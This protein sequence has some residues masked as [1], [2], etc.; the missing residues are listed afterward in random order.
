M[1]QQKIIYSLLLITLTIFNLNAQDFWKDKQVYTVGTE[2]HAATH[3]VY[4]NEA[5]ALKGNYQESPYYKSLAGNWKFNWAETPKDKPKDFHLSNFNVDDWSTIPVPACWERHGYGAPSHRGLGALVRAEKIK[6]PGVPDNDNHVGSYRTSF[7]IPKGWKNR[8]TLLHFNG[9]SSAFYLWINGELVGYD[10]DAMTSSVFDI[11]SFLKEGE[12]TIAVQ[13]YRWTTGSYL[14]SG[15]T[16]TFSGIFRDVYLQSRPNVQIKDFFLTSNL[17]KQYVDAKFNA[18]IKIHNNSEVVPKNYKVKIDIYDDAGEL[19]SESGDK[20]PKIGWRMG[21]LGAET[22]LEYNTNIKSPKLWS[23]EF[24]NL[25]TVVITL[26][27]AEGKTVEVT[28]SPFG[29]REIEMKNLQVHINGVP[30]KIKGA[31]RGE[32]HPETGK[33]LSEASMIQDILLMKQNNFNSVRSSHHPNDPR[34]YALCDKY[35]LYVMDEALESPDYFIRGN[36]LPGSD[37]GWMGAAL[38]RAVAMVERSKNHPSIIFWSLGN[39]SGYG[40]NFALMSDYIRRFDPTR[41][42]SYDGRETDCW[43][44]KDYFDMNSSMYPFI[45]DDPEQKHWKLLSFWADPKY[46]KPYIMIEY[47]HAQGNALGNFAEYWRVVNSTPS[48]V[49]GYIWDWVNQTYNTKMSDGRIRQSHKLDYHKTDTIATNKNFSKLKYEGNECAKGAVFSDRNEK[50]FMAE[51]K[52]AQQYI[53]IYADKNKK[54]VY[55]VDNKY[56]FSNLNHFN[57]SWQLIKDGEIIK[58]GNIPAFNTKPNETSEFEVSIPKLKPNAEYV[59]QFSYKLKK[60]TLWAKAGHEVAKEEIILQEWKPIEHQVSGTVD[61][62]ETAN[63]IVISGKN[64]KISFNKSSGTINSILNN[65]KELIAQTGTINGP[66]LN[67]YRSPIENDHKHYTKS[68]VKASLNDLVEKTIS[69]ETS[70]VDKSKVKIMIIKEFTSNSGSFNH[71][72]IYEINGNGTIKMDNKVTPTGF[73]D[74]TALPRIGLKL[75]LV[76]GLEDVSWYGR[77][78]QE[79]YPDRKESAHLGIYKSNATNLFTPYIVPQENGARSDTR[80]MELGFKNSKKSALTVTSNKPFIFSALHYDANDM[81]NASRPEFMQ[82]R[83]ETILSIDSE[84]LGLG[85]AS[86]GPPPLN[87]YLLPV[88]NYAFSFTFNLN[89]K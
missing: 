85:N 39:E 51:I 88:K 86:C 11:S 66:E 26:L 64:F 46:N 56:Y 52:K 19:I 32:S 55:H 45:E 33:T 27:D 15:D 72:C 61:V 44:V 63:K 77:G 10:E 9:V 69:V 41:L 40:Q 76:E 29:F 34:W 87:E 6:I 24:P 73:T 20:S 80:W 57:G 16:W 25:Y 7:K 23:A 8:Q 48:F 70:Q 22:I 43:D 5:A 28:Q 59:I 35:G 3:F 21:N 50:P 82:K 60:A 89:S 75:G 31:N 53:S 83:K 42:I 62:L 12:N 58:E 81:D 37:I 2:P 54:H 67:V 65:K 79:N 13:V 68:W 1:K 78:P 47:A 71:N 38:D 49:G 17:D 30:I 4:A 14:E 84:M 74:V 18:K 36:S